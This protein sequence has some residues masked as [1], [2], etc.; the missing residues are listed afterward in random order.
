MS[1]HQHGP[2]ARGSGAEKTDLVGLG[3][4]AVMVASVDGWLCSLVWR[5]YRS[6]EQASGWDAEYPHE[7][8]RGATVATLV[9][10]GMVLAGAV[11]GAWAAGRRSTRQRRWRYAAAGALAIHALLPVLLAADLPRFAVTG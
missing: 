1:V 5:G 2:D 4:F 11:L 3:A 8:L 7:Q 10:G 6:A 9:L